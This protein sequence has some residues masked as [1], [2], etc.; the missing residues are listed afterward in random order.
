MNGFGCRGIMSLSWD[1]MDDRNVR[2]GINDEESNVGSRVGFIKFHLM[3]V[4]GM[5]ATYGI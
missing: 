4:Y 1:C 3:D 2:E 5:L